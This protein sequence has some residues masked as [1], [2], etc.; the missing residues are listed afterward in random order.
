LRAAAIQLNSTE[1]A[2]RNLTAA[3]RLVRAAAADGATLVVMPEKWPALGTG[4]VLRANAQPLGGPLVSW[5]LQLAGELQIDLV[6]GSISELVPGSDK[7]ANTSIHAAAD[8]TLAAVYRKVHLFDVEVAGR[9]YHESEHESPGDAAVLSEAADGTELGLTICYDLRFGELYGALAAAGARVLC[10][11]A[12]FTLATTRDHWLVLLRARAI[13]NQCFV[14]AANQVGE[15]PGGMESG[16]E[17]VIIDPWGAVLAQAPDGEGF[18]SADLDFAAQDRIRAE[19][20]VMSHR[21]PH[22]YR[23]SGARGKVI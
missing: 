5:A 3:D 14:V 22:A 11:P 1:D 4:E 6:A 13:E 23:V 20:P 16:G 19:M 7:L 2:A 9:S 18:C 21:A 17:S 12:A 8:G 10:V 15:H